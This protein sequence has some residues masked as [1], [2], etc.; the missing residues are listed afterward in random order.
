MDQFSWEHG[1]VPDTA[2]KHKFESIKT[3]QGK[4][5]SQLL[6]LDQ[7]AGV[8]VLDE[9]KKFAEVQGLTRLFDF[10]H[11][12]LDEYIEFRHSDLGT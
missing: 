1:E 8:W 5:L 10:Q 2:M 7:V 11:G 4:V 6:D 12:T 3:V 9:V